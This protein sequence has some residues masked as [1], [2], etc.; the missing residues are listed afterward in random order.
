MQY[1]YPA[2]FT[3]N[4]LGGF[5]VL[6]PSFDCCATDGDNF[7]EAIQM[8]AEVLELTIES[9]IELGKQLPKILPLEAKGNKKV[10]YIAVNVDVDNA[11]VPSKEA[12]KLLG[13]SSARVRQMIL[14]GQLSSEKRGR[15]NYVYL[16]SIM[17]RLN[18]PR[19][20]GRPKN[21]KEA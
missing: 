11:L 3:P 1:V 13:V 16:W 4:E 20:A 19:S 14:S 2:I 21:T 12:A 17:E 9:E 8:A 6:F 5:S 18:N 15:N 7:E 10:I